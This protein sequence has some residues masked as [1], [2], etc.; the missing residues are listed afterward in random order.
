[1]KKVLIF[2]LVMLYAVAASSKF[3]SYSRID[4]YARNAPMLKNNENLDKLVQYLVYPYSD[5]EEKARVLLA[6][7]V[8]HIDYDEFVYN[9]IEE[10]NTTKGKRLRV[11][12]Q[13]PQNDILEIRAGV[14]GDIA[15]LYE[16]MGRMAGLD[17][18]VVNGNISGCTFDG[19]ERGSCA[20]AWN[21]VKING[22]WEYVDP[23][24]AMGNARELGDSRS[25]HA[26]NKALEKRKKGGRN[27]KPRREREIQEEWFLTDKKKMIQTHLADDEKW[28]LQKKKI[29]KAKFI[30]MSERGYITEK[31]SRERAQKRRME[32]AERKER[33]RQEIMSLGNF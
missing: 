30:G 9:K 25:F 3:I 31:K 33:Q 17:I 32:I 28:Q 13:I 20:H 1:M 29:S 18:E 23:T 24:W 8:Y 4:R 5:D 19:L 16:K 7:I 21:V 27:Y 26:Y 6:W 12:N 11:K 2:L 14:C 22:E 15:A 10:Y